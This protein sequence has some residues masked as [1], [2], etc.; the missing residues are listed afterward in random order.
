[1]KRIILTLVLMA[2]ATSAGAQIRNLET[3]AMEK[4]TADSIAALE[5][6]AK[7]AISDSLA[8][9]FKRAH[10][11][12]LFPIPTDEDSTYLTGVVV[13]NDSLDIDK[14][15][16]R[17][18]W[19]DSSFTNVV[20][21]KQAAGTDTTTVVVTRHVPAPFDSLYIFAASDSIGGGSVDVTVTGRSGTVYLSQTVT[22]TVANGLE[23]F[24]FYRAAA[25]IEEDCM[26]AY[27]YRVLA[28]HWLKVTGLTAK[29][30]N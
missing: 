30:A 21:A 26:I 17:A 8:A 18:N 7:V 5:T 25:V 20:L 14:V 6:R 10:L 13:L 22:P 27:R 29:L 15:N 24:V 28:G 2:W 3:I 4:V 11:P 19:P 12:M 16:V 1:M 23:R 9:A